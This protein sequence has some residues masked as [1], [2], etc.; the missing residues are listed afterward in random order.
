MR[1]MHS[2]KGY[3]FTGVIRVVMVVVLE[4]EK[5]RKQ[6]QEHSRGV[7]WCIHPTCTLKTYNNHILN[8][9]MIRKTLLEHPSHEQKLHFMGVLM[10]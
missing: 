9:L 6:Q 2:E 8:K 1:T 3:T 10:V 5:K 7:M 4:R